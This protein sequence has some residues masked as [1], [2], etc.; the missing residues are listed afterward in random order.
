MR[1]IT[2]AIRALSR[3][4]IVTTVAALSLGLGIGSNAAIYSVFHQMLRQEL[5]VR[6]PE[7]LVNFSARGPKPGGTSCGDEGSCEDVLS[8]PMFRDLERAKPAAFASMQAL[9]YE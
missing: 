8:Y 7:R 9:R 5:R 3:T 1:N 2:L 4:P 6:E